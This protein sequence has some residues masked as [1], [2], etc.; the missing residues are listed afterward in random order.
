[1]DHDVEVYIIQ[2]INFQVNQFGGVG[3]G[4]VV[5]FM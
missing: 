1:M 3:G 5:E 4:G 2:K